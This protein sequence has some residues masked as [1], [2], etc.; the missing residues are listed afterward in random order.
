MYTLKNDVLSY[1]L[2]D[3]GYNCSFF[4][5]ATNHEYVKIPGTVWKLIYSVTGTE[6]VEC[7]VWQDGQKQQISACKD[8]LILRCNSM[9]GEDGRLIDASLTLRFLSAPQGLRVIAELENRDPSVILQE[10][11]LTPV[12][13]V[14]SLSGRHNDDFIAWPRGL[15]IRIPNPAYNDLST[16]AGF[17]KYERHDQFHTDMDALYQSDHASM[18]WFDW[19]N[20]EEGLYIGSEDTTRQALCLHIERD[21]HLNVLRFGMI[22]YPMLNA[23]EQWQGQAIAC[24]PHLGDW[25]A[26]SRFYRAFMETSGGYVPPKRPDWC[27]DMTG[28]LRVILKQQHGKLNWDY[29]DIP[30]LYDEAAAAGF[31]T[32]YLLGWEKGGFARMWPDYIVDE[33]MGGV[34]K[35]K[36]G[37]DYVHKKGGRVL[38]F[39]S[40]ALVDHNSNFYLNE[41]GEKVPIRS[42]WGE[43]IPFSETYCGEGTYR[44]IGNPAMPM[45]L[46]CP[47]APL[48]QEKMKWAAKQCLELG[49]DGVL[50]DIGGWFPYFCY[51]EDHTHKKPSHSHESKAANYSDLRNY[52]KT[53][54]DNKIILMEHNVDIYGQSMDIS[55]GS[56]SQPDTR[57]LDPIS[58]ENLSDAYLDSRLSE[59]Y[60]YTFP[61][62]ITTNRECGQDEDHYRAMAGYSFLLGLR[63][64]MTVYRCCG[65]LKNLPNYTAYLMELNAL[66]HRYEKHLLRGLFV[67]TDGFTADNPYVYVKGWQAEDGTMAV[68]LWNPTSQSRTVTITNTQTGNATVVSV[69]AEMATAA[70]I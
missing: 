60:L 10:L 20:S 66:Y 46:A 16:Y 50:Y 17:R 40:Y 55:H 64:D 41:G 26:G 32:L 12:S 69:A 47:G 4:H 33:R 39:L 35:L 1:T 61:E 51:A 68:T 21:T 3:R 52:V 36:E 70:E 8:V 5:L 24:F 18:Q 67:D 56:N 34:E 54:G 42:L 63:F 25:H 37:I 27:R 29:S 44:K 38:M 59:M 2:D 28:W 57:L 62:L 53:F 6:Q 30:A 58:A 19:Y 48:W 15:G 23:G 43:D 65:S 31:N 11:Q 14:H 13:G 49:A 7:V 22:R 9:I 45:Y